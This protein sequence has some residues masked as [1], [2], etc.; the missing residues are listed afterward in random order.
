MYAKSSSLL[1]AKRTFEKLAV[2]N[3]VTW[4]A[5][6]AGH[7]LEGDYISV[8]QCL[9]NMEQ[10]GSSPDVAIFA[11]LLTACSHCGFLKEG[12]RYFNKLRGIHG[13]AFLIFEHYNCMVNLLGYTGCLTEAMDL[14][15]TMPSVPDMI[16]WKSL[17]SGCKTYGNTDVGSHCFDRLSDLDPKDASGYV[18]MSNMYL[19]AQALGGN[20][21]ITCS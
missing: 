2:R 13:D 8:D 9:L 10:Q 5:L 19:D 17:L 6:I 15:C 1:E 21:G 7:A 12:C 16:G 14:L 20:R 18:I 3:V 4:C 11:T